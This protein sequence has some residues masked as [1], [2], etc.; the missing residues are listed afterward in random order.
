MQIGPKMSRIL[1]EIEFKKLDI[2]CTV[3]IF[4]ITLCLLSSNPT[5]V[6]VKFIK[7]GTSISI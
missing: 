6:I 2:L 5:I 1:A 7:L 3:L 4:G